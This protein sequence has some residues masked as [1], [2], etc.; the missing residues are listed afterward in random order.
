[1]SRGTV[2]WLISLFMRK[3][4]RLSVMIYSHSNIGYIINCACLFMCLE[5]LMYEYRNVFILYSHGYLN[6]RM[7]TAFQ[8]SKMLEPY[9]YENLKIQFC[10]FFGGLS[11]FSKIL[12]TMWK[13]VCKSLVHYWDILNSFQLFQVRSRLC[14]FNEWYIIQMQTYSTYIIWKYTTNQFSKLRC[15]SSKLCQ[16]CP[17]FRISLFLIVMTSIRDSF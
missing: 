4:R 3:L 2:V 14:Q 5:I 6:A 15:I 9:S 1:M 8:Y 13:M 11:L 16:I 17:I 7:L 10:E 12:F